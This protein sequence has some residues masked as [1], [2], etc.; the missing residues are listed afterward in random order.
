MSGQEAEMENEKRLNEE[1]KVLENTIA[2][3]RK[4]LLAVPAH[5]IEEKNYLR[6]DILAT[7][8]S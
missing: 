1:I 4:S 3:L 6:Q 8:P 2:V 7:S 5:S